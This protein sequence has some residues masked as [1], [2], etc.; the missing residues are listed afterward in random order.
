M[1]WETVAVDKTLSDLKQQGH[2]SVLDLW[3]SSGG[4]TVLCDSRELENCQ[5]HFSPL[6]NSTFG[7]LASLKDALGSTKEEE[8]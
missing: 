7:W 6:V 3:A 8:R 1:R 4:Q 5:E 2:C